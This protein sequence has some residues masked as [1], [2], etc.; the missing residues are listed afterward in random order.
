LLLVGLLDQ[1]PNQKF[2][3]HQAIVP[4]LARVG[5]S[6]GEILSKC[7]SHNSEQKTL[8][9]Q[10]SP[11]ESDVLQLMAKGAS[12]HQAASELHLSEYTV[13]DYVSAI[14]QKMDAQNRTEAVARA[15]RENII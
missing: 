9:L 6:A 11:R 14:M 1:A 5:Q 7:T 10:L 4:A 15:I 12:T 13:R 8:A 2:Q 3:L